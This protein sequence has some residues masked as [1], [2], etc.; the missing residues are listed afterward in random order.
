MIDKGQG[1]RRGLDKKP[2]VRRGTYGLLVTLA[3]RNDALGGL[4]NTWVSLRGPLEKLREMEAFCQIRGA[5]TDWQ[6]E[7]LHVYIDKT[8]AQCLW[9]AAHRRGIRTE[10]LRKQVRYP[11]RRDTQ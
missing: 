10:H 4:L 2:R 3:P 8:Y 9:R 11:L 6:G 5:Q 1:K 7:H